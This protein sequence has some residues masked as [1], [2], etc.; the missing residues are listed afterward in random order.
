MYKA[1]AVF[2]FDSGDRGEKNETIGQ[3]IPP[4][5]LIASPAGKQAKHHTHLSPGQ[6]DLIRVLGGNIAP[7]LDMFDRVAAGAGM[8]VQAVL[9][10]IQEWISSGLIRRFA[11]VL[12]HRQAGFVANGMA[13]FSI[14]ETRI[15]KIGA[16]LAQYA[17]ISHCYHRLAARNWP[18]NLFTMVHGRGFEEVTLFVRQLAEKHDLGRY[19]ILFSTHQYKKTSMQYFGL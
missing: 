6:I 5:D 19:E 12:A 7:S 16:K 13:V 11:A 4:A 3:S 9:E 14:D 10:Q 17:N 1:S 8:S 15:D 18:Y 2:A